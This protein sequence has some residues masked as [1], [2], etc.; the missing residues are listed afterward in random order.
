MQAFLPAT[1][2][3]LGRNSYR[4]KEV[5]KR[6]SIQSKGKENMQPRALEGYLPK[7]KFSLQI[8]LFSKCSLPLYRKKGRKEEELI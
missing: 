2:V 4:L 8:V 1:S 3:Q 5:C 6:G 7:S